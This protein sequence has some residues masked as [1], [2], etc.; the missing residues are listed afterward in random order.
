MLLS[1]LRFILKGWVDQLFIQPKFFF[2]FFSW[3]S[4]LPGNAMYIVFATLAIVS[5]LIMIGRLYLPS[6][7]TFFILFT[8]VELLDKTNYLNHYY[9]ISVLSLLLCIIPATYIS[10]TRSFKH[11]YASPLF[12]LWLIRLQVGLVYFFAGVAKLKASWLIDAQPLK[13][14]LAANS[15]IPF[16]GG[17]L[18]E[19]WVAYF[20][21][22]FAMFFDLTI[23]FWLMYKRTTYV[24]YFFVLLF[25]CLTSYFFYI[26]VFP[27]V[28]SSC[29]L[30]FFSSDFHRKVV[31]RFNAKVTLSA[32]DTTIESTSWRPRKLILF[33]FGLFFALQALL[34]F[35]YLLY[36]GYLLWTEQG[37]RF[38]WNVM[39][40]EKTGMCEFTVKDKTSQKEVVVN[41]RNFLTPLQERMMSTQPDMIVQYAHFLG[42]VYK[43][44]GMHQ[45]EVYADCYIALN[46]KP[47]KQF[48]DNTYNLMQAEDNF[49]NKKWILPFHP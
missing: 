19:S 49:Q 39:L 4:P 33:C 5:F 8:Y 3:L 47:S 31:Q 9:F 24:A 23:P 7:I 29:A 41:N 44:Q 1:V 37:F 15:S 36:P 18:E 40:M 46:G 16:I 14:W 28:M 38:S 26:G 34:P 22:W 25:H 13:I 48:I 11:T 43:N 6:I 32:G 21:S 45:P 12:F 20:A 17:L 27:L 10:P 35:R 2:P 30:I 42:E